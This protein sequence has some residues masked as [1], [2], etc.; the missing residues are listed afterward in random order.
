MPGC[1]SFLQKGELSRPWD[2]T[3]HGADASLSGMGAA[4][5]AA[6]LTV[7]KSV[8]SISERW[9]ADACNFDTP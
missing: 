3:V 8:G 7:V 4:A 2:T 9:R 5:L 1:Y 6:P